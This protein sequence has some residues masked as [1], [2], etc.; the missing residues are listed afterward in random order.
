MVCWVG[1]RLGKLFCKVHLP[2]KLG[3]EMVHTS[4]FIFFPP[5][6]GLITYLTFQLPFNRGGEHVM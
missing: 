2:S 3:E 6:Y 1:D 4:Y 5:R